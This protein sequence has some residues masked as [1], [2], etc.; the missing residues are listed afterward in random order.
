MYTPKEKRRKRN[1]RVLWRLS[2]GVL[3]LLLCL[4]G[5]GTAENEGKGAESM[6]ESTVSREETGSKPVS[7]LY[8]TYDNAAYTYPIWEEGLVINETVMFVE[9]EDGSVPPA[10]LLYTPTKVIGVR[11][12]TMVKSYEEGLDYIIEGNT[13]VRTENSRIPVMRY[14]EYYPESE[15]PG[16]TMARTGGGYICFSEGDFFHNQQVA[17]TYEHEDA[18]N[19]PVPAYKGDRLPNTV[20]KLRDGETLT[21]VLNGD[22]I[23]AGGNSSQVIGALPLIPDW[24]TMFTDS[25]KRVYPAELVT[26]NTAVGGQISTWGMQNAHELVGQYAPDLAILAFGMNDSL[27]PA[28]FVRTTQATMEKIREDAPDCEFILVGGI[29][30]NKEFNGFWRQQYA[31]EEALLAL[32]Q[33]GVAVAQVTSLHRY[34]LETKRYYDMSGNNVNH[35]ND[36][37]ARLYAQVLNALLI[38]CA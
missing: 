4:S 15:I 37:L 27:T 23:A 2:G 21:I 28:E 35:C 20:K 36:F 11:S 25:L 18:W 9:N 13:L 17:I 3:A 1:S 26:H 38:P 31:Y 22:S 32:E 6:I 24:F 16:K 14:D 8:T 10:P 29:V 34:L 5:C 7:R 30:P 19:G 33:P 12:A